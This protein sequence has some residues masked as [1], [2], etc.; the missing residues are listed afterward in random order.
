MISEC[1]LIG[2]LQQN[3]CLLDDHDSDWVH[4]KFE[5]DRDGEAS[6]AGI[7]GERLIPL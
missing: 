3:T 4:D 6:T 5:D 2:L 7:D 1:F